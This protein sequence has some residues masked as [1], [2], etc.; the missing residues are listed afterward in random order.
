M[1]LYDTGGAYNAEKPYTISEFSAKFLPVPI[2]PKLRERFTVF[3]QITVCYTCRHNSRIN[4]PNLLFWIFIRKSLVEYVILHIL[5]FYFIST[6][7]KTSL[8]IEKLL[9][10]WHHFGDVEPR[11]VFHKGYG[12]RNTRLYSNNSS[13]RVQPEFSRLPRFFYAVG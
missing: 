9:K 13:D 1:V 11:P 10:L 8:K 12:R 3:L 6:Y 4:F 5:V 2:S 7:G